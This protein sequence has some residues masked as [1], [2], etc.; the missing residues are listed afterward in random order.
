LAVLPDVH[1]AHW[2]LA[3]GHLAEILAALALFSAEDFAIP[4]LILILQVEQKPL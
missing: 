4:N 3:S 1:S 2:Y